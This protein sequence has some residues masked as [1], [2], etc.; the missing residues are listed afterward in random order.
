MKRA[1]ITFCMA[2]LL[3][4]TASCAT[5]ISGSTQTISISASPETAKITLK[6]SKGPISTAQGHLRI[7]LD[8][9]SGFFQS[10]SYTTV[11]EKK[12]YE[13]V[14]VPI[15]AGLNG[16]YVGNFIFGGLIGFLIVDPASG[17]MWT[18]GPTKIHRNLA[19]KTAILYE[20]DP[21][22]RGTKH[23]HIII[24]ERDEL[25]PELARRLVP[26]PRTKIA[27]AN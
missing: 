16:W 12:G 21:S 27:R 20:D 4:F 5:I 9:G 7:T 14:R 22:Q 19:K 15:R 23:L 2:L 13:K 24:K 3:V 1:I 6:D 10:A 11:L 17:A 25:S 18:L 8:R 26:I